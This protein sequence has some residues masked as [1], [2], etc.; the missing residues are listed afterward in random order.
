MNAEDY[1]DYK[2]AT[3]IDIKEHFR[4]LSEE[5]DKLPLGLLIQMEHDLFYSYI[6]HI[7]MLNKVLEGKVEE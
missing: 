4:V 1:F 6:T 7:E 5:M 3:I 2:N